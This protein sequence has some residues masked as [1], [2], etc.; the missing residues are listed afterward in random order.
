[1]DAFLSNFQLNQNL[2]LEQW[3]WLYLL[4]FVAA[5]YLT[6]KIFDKSTNFLL[7]KKIPILR[8]APN[9]HLKKFIRPVGKMV[10]LLVLFF[11]LKFMELN[12][13]QMNFMKRGILIVF[14][15]IIV[16]FAH[17]L[18]HMATFYFTEKAQRTDSK[19]DDIL[20]P[21]LSKSAF[22]LVY[23][24]GLVYILHS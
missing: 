12:E 9:D 14:S 5:A 18:V 1:M 21:L 19:F 13:V 17:Y 3:Q 15:V 22:V 4:G 23:C 16:W 8:N 7:K 20:I 24:I 2:L 10:F 6:E 11:G